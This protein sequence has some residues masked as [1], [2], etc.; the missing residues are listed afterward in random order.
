[1]KDTNPTPAYL[2]GLRT[3][4][5]HR[6]SGTGINP[7][8]PLEAHPLRRTV[9]CLYFPDIAPQNAVKRLNR[10]IQGDPELLLLLRY[11]GYRPR[12]RRFTPK[13]MRVLERYL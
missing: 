4:P 9:A 2:M 3:L 13:Q 8:R 11:Y 7:A 1:M 12:S 10:W 5:V 6:H